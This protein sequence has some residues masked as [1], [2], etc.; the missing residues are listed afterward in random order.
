MD[1][2]TNEPIVTVNQ[3]SEGFNKPNINKIIIA[4][5]N[6]TELDLIQKMSR[7]NRLF[8]DKKEYEVY[9]LYTKKTQ[10]EVWF[11]KMV[12]NFDYTVIKC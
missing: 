3:L 10:E 5:Y 9:I 2:Y 6:S 4:Q 1:N 8:K 7:A 12:E 11:N